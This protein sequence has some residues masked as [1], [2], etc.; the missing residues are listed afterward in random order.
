[1]TNNT[2]QDARALEAAVDAA[3][4]A[5]C[6]MNGFSFDLLKHG[7]GI[8]A[9]IMRQ[10]MREVLDAALATLPPADAGLVGK[11]P[12]MRSMEEWASYDQKD[13]LVLLLVEFE[14]NATEDETIA[15]TIGS[16]TDHNVGPEEAEGWKMAGWNWCH[17]CF[18]SGQGKPIGWMPLPHHL[19]CIDTA[20]S[21]QEG[22]GGGEEWTKRR[23]HEVLD[24]GDGFWKPCCGC[25]ES[26]DGYVSTKD[27]PYSEIYRCHP[28]AGC[29]ECGGIGV[30]WDDTD[31]E[32]Y[33][34]SALQ[35]DLATLR[36][37]PA[38]DDGLVE[39]LWVVN[40]VEGNIRATHPF[41]AD[42][43]MKAWRILTALRDNGHG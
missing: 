28:G 38:A 30:V 41:Q 10:E 31:Y 42:R 11:W 32:A 34:R 39:A 18:T 40:V 3:C 23:I 7:E 25:Q 35:D 24:E 12:A 17:D 14:E 33:A 37:E 4:E 27:Y 15:L 29:G 6:K 20:L 5:K 43:L 9:T 16:N 1:M 36:P 26:C 19:A 21:G 13:D 8:G 2:E 22:A